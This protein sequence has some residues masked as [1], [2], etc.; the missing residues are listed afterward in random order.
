MYGINSLREA[1]GERATTASFSPNRC[2]QLFLLPRKTV[3]D[4]PARYDEP[5]LTPTRCILQLNMSNVG[6]VCD[7]CGALGCKSRPAE[8]HARPVRRTRHTAA[9]PR[10]GTVALRHLYVILL[11]IKLSTH[12][13]K[14]TIKPF[15]VFGMNKSTSR[16]M[17]VS[18]TP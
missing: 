9:L 1:C 10:E 18:V 2:D 17:I 13:V 11:P 12:L 6:F 4:P 16:N 7:S 15:R 5:D 3:C 14:V 8:A